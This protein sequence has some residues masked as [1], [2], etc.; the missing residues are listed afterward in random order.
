MGAFV[1]VCASSNATTVA[2]YDPAIVALAIVVAHSVDAGGVCVAVVGP[3][4]TL[5]NVVTVTF[6]TGYEAVFANAFVAAFVV[7]AVGVGATIA[8]VLFTF[9]DIFAGRTRIVTIAFVT[10]VAD[11][12]V[13]TTCVAT[14]RVF[15]T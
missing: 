8:T 14:R 15:R 9:V 12:V 4:F 11:A 3:C 2:D 7:G 5:I 10:V 13:A 1:N 6:A